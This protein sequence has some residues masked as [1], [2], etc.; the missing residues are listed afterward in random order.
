MAGQVTGG[1][2]ERTKV[3]SLA[4]SAFYT[5]VV[6]EGGDVFVWGACYL[7]GPAP[8]RAEDPASLTGPEREQWAEAARRA[9]QPR[10]VSEAVMG[11]G[12]TDKVAAGAEHWVALGR[13]GLIFTARQ[14][15]V[16]SLANALTA[17]ATS[18]EGARPL[19]GT[20][21]ASS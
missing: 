7:E 4:A 21:G 1:G 17:S 10:R 9:G 14:A 2:L 16:P 19:S 20:W 5:L 12:E 13:N 3:V 15:R 8:F 18:V 6:S 11:S